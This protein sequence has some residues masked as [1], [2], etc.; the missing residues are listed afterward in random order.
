MSEKPEHQF[1][2]LAD[3]ITKDNQISDKPN[4]LDSLLCGYLSHFRQGEFPPKYGA[5]ELIQELNKAGFKIVKEN[6]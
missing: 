5:L 6:K 4:K 1:R 3:Q 2:A